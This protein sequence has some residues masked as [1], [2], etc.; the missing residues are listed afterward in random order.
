MILSTT[1][2]SIATLSTASFVITASILKRNNEI[3][4]YE[5]KRERLRLFTI[6]KI[7]AIIISSKLEYEGISST[8]TY[9]SYS[10]P[11]DINTFSL[12][13]VED[14]L[15]KAENIQSAS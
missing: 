4:N 5:E 8:H 1:F 13:Q 11:I 10:V 12:Q 2:G 9:I 3:K 6:D 7:R 15:I 14:E